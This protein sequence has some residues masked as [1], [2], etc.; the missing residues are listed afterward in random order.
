MSTSE[1][2]PATPPTPTVEPG[3]CLLLED[4]RNT[5]EWLSQVVLSAFPGIE[6]VVAGT[7]REAHAQLDLMAGQPGTPLTLGILD[8]GLP[9]GSGVEIIRRITLEWPQALAVVA[10]IYSDDAHVFDAISAGAR[11]YILKDEDEVSLV[12]Y[13]KRIERGEPPLAPSIAHRILAHFRGAAP[14][15]PDEARL[16]GREIETL[17]LIAR[18]LTVSEAA[19]RLG[20][21]PQT[22]ASYVKVIYQKLNVTSRAQATREA[23]R[24]GLA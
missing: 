17:S 14:T 24:R 19:T 6:I 5:R 7:V 9:D 10:T 2:P 21:T 22:V 3:R 20:L 18:G 23:I 13:L 15:R 8:I 16:T 11:G 12:Q 1:P 4:Q